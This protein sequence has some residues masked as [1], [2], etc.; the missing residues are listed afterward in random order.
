LAIRNGGPLSVNT[1]FFI[2]IISFTGT[3]KSGSDQ[4]TSGKLPVSMGSCQPV[5][6]QP[7]GRSLFL[8]THNKVLDLI[9][10]CK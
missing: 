7:A 6:G 3:I 2:Y 10:K 9:E 5:A 4:K 1:V 8:G